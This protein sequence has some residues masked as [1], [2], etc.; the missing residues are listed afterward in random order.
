MRR[1]K[2]LFQLMQLLRWDRS[3]TVTHLAA[4]LAV[5]ERT[6]YRDMAALMASG[7]SICT[8]AQAA[9]VL[10]KFVD[11]R[12]LIIASSD[13]SHYYSYATAR[14]LDE[15]CV[16]AICDLDIDTMETQE[17]CGRIPILTLMHLA[18][19]RGWKACLLDRRNRFIAYR[20]NT[21]LCTGETGILFLGM[22][23]SLENLL[24]KDINVIYPVAPSP[25]PEERTSRLSN[26][27]S[28]FLLP[29]MRTISV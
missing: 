8:P 20:I 9:A 10:G 26:P 4:E 1:T 25:L 15:R 22:L 28:G 5:S 24:N 29:T 7:V 14:K 6:I 3:R 12:T 17:A 27:R 23:H 11:D 16:K 21:T 19:E 18:R 13:L 2:R